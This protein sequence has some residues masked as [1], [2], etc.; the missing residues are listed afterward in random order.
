[1]KR[2]IYVIIFMLIHESSAIADQFRSTGSIDVYFSPKGGAT[3]AIVKEIKN[4]NS[5]ILVQAFSCI[6][7][8]I[9]SALID[10]RNRGLKV[11]VILDKRQ[12]K[13]GHS[14]AEFLAQ[15]GVPVYIDALHATANSNIMIIDGQTLITG[16]FVFTAT[17]E[18]KNAENLLVIRGNK[19][20]VNRYIKNFDEHHIHSG[21]YHLK[22]ARSFKSPTLLKPALLRSAP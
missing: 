17:S 12:R 15:G 3:E 2:I 19:Q 20:L 22:Y 7:H 9:T 1:M 10:A 13:A 5:E 18:D 8:S 21:P 11:K 6:S 4:S 14:S 16:S